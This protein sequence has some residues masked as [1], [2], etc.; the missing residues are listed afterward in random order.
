MSSRHKDHHESR[1]HKR[2]PLIVLFPPLLA[3]CLSSKHREHLWARRGDHVTP[4]TYI[5]E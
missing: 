1:P 2:L 5:V 3:L 4:V